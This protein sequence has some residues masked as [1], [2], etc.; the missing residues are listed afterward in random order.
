[1]KVWVWRYADKYG[2]EKEITT[3]GPVSLAELRDHQTMLLGHMRQNAINSGAP[4][5]ECKPVGEPH[6]AGV[7][8]ADLGQWKP[9]NAKPLNL[10]EYE[11]PDDSDKPVLE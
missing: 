3:R 7:S 2:N 9:A 11:T 6:E 10:R 4:D 8:T 5:P 1:M